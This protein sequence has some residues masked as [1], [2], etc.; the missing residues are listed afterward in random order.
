MQHSLFDGD[1]DLPPGRPAMTEASFL[2]TIPNIELVKN[3]H[4]EAH[5]VYIG[6]GSRWGNPYK[7][8][9]DGDRLAV[10]MRYKRYLWE[11]LQDGRLTRDDLLS[12]QGKTLGCYCAPKPCHGHVLQCAIAWAARFT[13]HSSPSFQANE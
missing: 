3:R 11:C 7:I 1:V 2:A 6:R 4:Y 10:I 13:Y 12:L 5:E 8:G 9:V